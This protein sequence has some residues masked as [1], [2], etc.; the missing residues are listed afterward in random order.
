M[1]VR[2]RFFRLN[3]H[4]KGMARRHAKHERHDKIRYRNTQNRRE[5]M[6][7]KEPLNYGLNNKNMG[8]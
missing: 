4:P 7:V 2:V 1:R 8:I 6:K 5:K 3:T